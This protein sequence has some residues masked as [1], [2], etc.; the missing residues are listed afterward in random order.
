[1]TDW[2]KKRGEAFAIICKTLR[3]LGLGCVDGR[4]FI[5]MPM[6]YIMKP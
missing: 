1:M 6:V 5:F 4:Y 3:P 2:G